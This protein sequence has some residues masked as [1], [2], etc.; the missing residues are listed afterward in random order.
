ML[1]PLKSMLLFNMIIFFWSCTTHRAAASEA[2]ALGRESRLQLA[3]LSN[4]PSGWPGTGNFTQPGERTSPRRQTRERAQPSQVPIPSRRPVIDADAGDGSGPVPTLLVEEAPPSEDLA[5]RQT[6]KGTDEK[7]QAAAAP[8]AD[9]PVWQQCSQGNA[10]TDGERLRRIEACTEVLARSPAEPEKRR[11]EALRERAAAYGDVNHDL[12][13]DD[14]AALLELDPDDVQILFWRSHHYVNQQQFDAAT[15]DLDRIVALEPGNAKAFAER[16]RVHEQKGDIAS[17]EKDYRK[18]V[19]IAPETQEYAAF[20]EAIAETTSATE[21]QDDKESVLFDNDDKLYVSCSNFSASPDERISACNAVI[22]KLP[23][24][25]IEGAYFF[26]EDTADI[27]ASLDKVSAGV[28]Y[29]TTWT[30]I[31]TAIGLRAV[32]H[33]DKNDMQSALVDINNAIDKAARLIYR[34]GTISTLDAMML[35]RG[36]LFLK[37]EEYERAEDDF[38]TVTRINLVPDGHAH[39]ALLHFTRGR[40]DQAQEEIRI[41]LKREP[42]NALAFLVRGRISLEKGDYQ[43]A[44]QDCQQAAAIREANKQK[45][46]PEML[47]CVEK[48]REALPAGTQPAESPQNSDKLE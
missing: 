11:R 48:A 6:A 38:R 39:M 1:A 24:L 3:Q 31:S 46:S 10:L 2:V 26:A 40:Y 47:A 25:E 14:Y 28:K 27:S 35:F 29:D 19:E 8:A 43:L 41:A 44:F 16:G 23:A 34:D 37:N 9:D 21:R 4:S 36:R 45:A 33:Y 5:V 22:A 7:E 13:V 17:A 30:R 18:A 32:A 15:A 12:A 20:L 42:A